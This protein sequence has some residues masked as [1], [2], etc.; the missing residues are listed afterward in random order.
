M[1]VFDVVW[2]GIVITAGVLLLAWAAVV[3][4]S[5]FGIINMPDDMNDEI[6]GDRSDN[7]RR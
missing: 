4:L 6:I 5:L 7:A 1:D 3:V 2:L